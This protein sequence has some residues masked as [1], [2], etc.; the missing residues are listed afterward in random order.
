MSLSSLVQAA[1]WFLGANEENNFT[2]I[3]QIQRKK[4]MK[5][6]K[7]LIAVILYYVLTL[8]VIFAQQTDPTSGSSKD[9]IPDTQLGKITNEFI[10]AINLPE[11]DAVK[12]FANKYLKENLTSVSGK[13][14]T[15]EKYITLLQSIK[16]DGGNLTLVGLKPGADEN[17]LAAIFSASKASNAIGIEFVLNQNGDGLSSLEP[18]ALSKPGKPYEWPAGKFTFEEIVSAIDKKISIDFEAGSFSGNVLIAK[19]DKILMNKSYGYA[20][21]ENKIYNDASTRFHTGSVGKMIT[22]TA[23]AQLVESG[24]I[25]FTDTLGNVLS[26]FPNPEAAKKITIEQ[27]LTHTTGIADPFETGRRRSGED[28][29]TAK[30]NLPL[31][32]D[33]AL[34]FEPGLKHSYSNGNYTVLALIVE[35]VSGSSFESYLRE[36]IFIPSGMQI[37]RMDPY[38]DLQLAKRYSYSVEN[39]PFALNSK[40]AVN[41]PANDIKFEYSGYCNGYLT[42]EDVYKFLYALKEGKLVSKEMIEVI[43]SGKVDV[44]PG[45]PVKYAYG[46]YDLN[47]WG[48]NFRGHS[49]GGGNSGIGAEAEMIW[50][51]DYFIVALGNCDLEKVRPMV[52]SIVRFLGH[53][54]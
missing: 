42:A 53:Q 1:S 7:I 36:N 32:A 8:S 29:S 44:E 43:T 12:V 20:D 2:Y 28:Y 24:K 22:A 13:I 33:L 26:N 19:G 31:F 4:L 6:S 34:K 15:S 18:H 27:L 54:D 17:Y 41:N 52:F 21:A 16:R 25:K 37:G 35:E 51:N 40:I 23:I 50:N 9:L 47:L 45:A 49:G 48:V 3:K 46:F 38:R 11:D 5:S 14:W 30:N 39:D 10:L